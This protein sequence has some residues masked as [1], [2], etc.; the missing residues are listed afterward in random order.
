[1]EEKDIRNGL[2]KK[3]IVVDG[4]NCYN[5]VLQEKLIEESNTDIILVLNHQQHIKPGREA[6]VK[7]V[8]ASNG[9]KNALDFVVVTIA[10]EQL[11]SDKYGKVEIVSQDRGFV[12]AVEYLQNKG[13]NI[14]VIEPDRA[15]IVQ[16]IEQKREKTFRSLCGFI[17]NNTQPGVTEAKLRSLVRHK[18]NIE[19][20]DFAGN[21]EKLGYIQRRKKKVYYEKLE[22]KCLASNNLMI[23]DRLI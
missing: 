8:R 1:M 22:L 4:E 5:S 18:L 10:V 13:H 14:D 3:L 9:I 7:I 15:L 17:A 20:S 6:G 19:L 16:H 21:L 11:L 12:S 2:R 23:G